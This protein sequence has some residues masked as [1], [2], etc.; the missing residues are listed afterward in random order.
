MRQILMVILELLEAPLVLEILYLV[1]V[2]VS[3]QEERLRR[4]LQ[5]ADFL[6][7]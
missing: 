2:V 3:V 1:R 6:F 5:G 4:E 7:V